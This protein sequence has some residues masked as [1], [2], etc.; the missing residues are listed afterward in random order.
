M[1]V[2]QPSREQIS[3]VALD[4]LITGSGTTALKIL[5][6]FPSNTIFENLSS[7][8]GSRDPVS[9]YVTFA[10]RTVV[11]VQD[12]FQPSASGVF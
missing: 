2:L 6:D 7:F 3:G 11:G 4:S 9:G 5:Y 10:G 1:T 8:D 12:V